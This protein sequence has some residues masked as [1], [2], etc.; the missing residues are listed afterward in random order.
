M[1]L[2][3]AIKSAG[4]A[5]ITCGVNGALALLPSR[6]RAIVAERAPMV[7][8]LDYGPTR[9]LLHVDSELEYR[10][11][12]RSASKEPDTVRWIEEA[13]GDGDVFYDIGA[14]VGAYSL[15]AASRF[16][17]L[18]VVAFEPSALNFGQLVRNVALNGCGDR[19]MPLAVAL[20]DS[21]RL[22]TFNYQNLTRGGA[23][24]TIGRAVSEEGRAFAPA[25]RQRVRIHRLDDVVE[26]FDLPAPTHIKVDV[27]GAEPLVLRGAGDTLRH[28]MLR[29]VLVETNLEGPVRHE[30][31]AVLTAAGLK[32]RAIHP[33]AGGFANFI[34]VREGTA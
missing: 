25:L 5:A 8:P 17:A 32:L 22:D 16:P 18:R 15:I 2:T 31:E 30:V 7:R 10:V 4:L 6:L 1:G 24:H 11:R 9:V 23:L 34:F 14:N 21:T 19:V 13:F 28:P 20:A 29:T 33:Y 12:L 26:M 27:D 3:A